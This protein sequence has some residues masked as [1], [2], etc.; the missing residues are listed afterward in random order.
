MTLPLNGCG[1]RPS[2][3]SLT[4]SRLPALVVPIG[5]MI[6][7]DASSEEAQLRTSEA[8]LELARANLARTRDLAARKVITDAGFGP[9]Y[10]IPGLP[11][12][13]GP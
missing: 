7:L 11:H 13:T 10:K 6:S 4:V 9:G 1:G 8:D 2:T 12:R 3:E 5:G